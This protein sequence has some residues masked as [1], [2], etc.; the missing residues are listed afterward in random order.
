MRTN[1]EAT[2]PLD[3]H[4]GP[5]EG[6]GQLLAATAHVRRGT[7]QIQRNVHGQRFGGAQ[8]HLPVD[9]HLAR[10]HQRARL[11]A[12]A[13]QPSNDQQVVETLPRG[14]ARRG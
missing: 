1:I 5:L 8:R 11:I 9:Q 6:M 2:P 7:L 10:H 3:R 14:T 12:A 4:A 13:R